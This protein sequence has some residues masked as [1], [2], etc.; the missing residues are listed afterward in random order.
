[1]TDKHASAR[2]DDS[3]DRIDND[4]IRALLIEQ[5]ELHNRYHALVPQKVDAARIALVAVLHLW[6]ADPRAVEEGDLDAVRAALRVNGE[7]WVRTHGKDPVA[8]TR[9]QIRSLLERMRAEV[10]RRKYAQRASTGTHGAGTYPRHGY[11]QRSPT[12]LESRGMETAARQEIRKTIGR[13]IA[14]ARKWADITA[15]YLAARLGIPPTRVSDYERGRIRPSDERLGEIV[16]IIN[17]VAQARMIPSIGWFYDE[18]DND[19]SD[20]E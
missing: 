4:E 3:S 7:W 16:T 19:T 2:A 10:V 13:N 1:M 12:V 20:A 14:L 17:D 8:G 6:L 9:V 5:A 11:R 15:R 18:H